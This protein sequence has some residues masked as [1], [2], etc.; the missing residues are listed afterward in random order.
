MAEGLGTKD[1]KIP[2]LG[3]ALSGDFW[4]VFSPGEGRVVQVGRL[5]FS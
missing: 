5:S 1:G 4:E 2:R 3:T